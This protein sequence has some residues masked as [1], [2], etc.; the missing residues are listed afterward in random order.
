MIQGIKQSWRELRRGRPGHRFQDEYRKRQEAGRS[1]VKRVAG[2][3]AGLVVLAAGIF[4]LPAP[5]PGMVI[6]A[7]GAAIL[8]RESR[9]AARALDW[10]ELR[11]RAV[12]R[13][14]RAR[15]QAAGWPLRVLLVLVAAAIAA[16]AGYLAWRV[17]FR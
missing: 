5:G 7:L 10:T 17:F 15:W 6:V 1:P 3:G 11:V 14:G 16:G 9:I 12:L 4:F 13:W 8:A 2:I